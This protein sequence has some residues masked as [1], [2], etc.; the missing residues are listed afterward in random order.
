MD[1]VRRQGADGRF[2]EGIG[3][4]LPDVV[5]VCRFKF[6]SIFN[7]VIEVEACVVAGCTNEF[8]LGVD[9]M[10]AKTMGFHRNEARC[11]HNGRSVVIIFRTQGDSGK[12]RVATVRMVTK[13][14]LAGDAVASVQM[15]VVAEDGE[16]GRFIPTT[17]TGSVMLAATITTAHHGRAWVPATNANSTAAKLPSKKELG[18]W[19]PVDKDMTIVAMNGELEPNRLEK[20]LD[21]QGDAETPLDDE[22]EIRVGDAKPSTR[23]LFTKLLRIYRQLTMNKSDCPPAAALDVH[24]HIDTGDS[25]PIMLKRRRQ[26]QMKDE[27]V[28]ENVT[29][30]LQAG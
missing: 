3:G 9:F 16:Q 10:T 13:A 6:R 2:V 12:A 20:W 30:I 1:G 11:A 7:G 15:S 8:L 14:S 17:Y 22:N 4:Y 21:S 26:A 23:A 24:H 27:I 25:A 29:K 19:L 28:D 5:G 18:T